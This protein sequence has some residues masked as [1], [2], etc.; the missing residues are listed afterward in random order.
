[1]R[2]TPLTAAM[3]AA[4]VLALVPGLAQAQ[5]SCTDATE[6]GRLI[7]TGATRTVAVA[8]AGISV[9]MTAEGFT[10][11][12]EIHPR[13]WMTRSRF[14]VLE[15]VAPGDARRME[16]SSVL[17]IYNRNAQVS[18]NDA[19]A[20][21]WRDQALDVLGLHWDLVTMHARRFDID[22]EMAA[23]LQ[24]NQVILGEMDSIRRRAA[25]L[26]SALISQQRKERDDREALTR[27]R[28]R[29]ANLRAAMD[30]ARAAVATAKTADD[31]ARAQQ[32]LTNL[33]NQLNAASN[34]LQ[35]A[36]RMNSGEPAAGQLQME[37][38]NEEGRMDLLKARL[39]D[40]DADKRVEWLRASR[41]EVSEELA[42]V[43]EQRLA[44]A[45]ETLKAT[46]Q[47]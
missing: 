47:R 21:R 36:E 13:E 14:V 2:S 43:V 27:A 37:M 4:F 35:R 46:L 16:I 18:S 8:A 22:A 10:D 24:L 28:Q 26:N 39:A 6:S 32:N 5:S 38:R 44:R 23:T 30:R 33:E 19:A 29:H 25:E 45:V 7:R 11:S 20:T 15:S 17:T 12:L 9:C 42:K 34:A 31:Q 1:M 40:L 41:N 3:R